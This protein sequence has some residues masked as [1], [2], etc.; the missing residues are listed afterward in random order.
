MKKTIFLASLAVS[1]L[2]ANGNF[3]HTSHWGYT[4]HNSPEH[5]AEIDDRFKMCSLG[6]SQSPINISKNVLVETDDLNPIEFNYHAHS[7]D[8]VNNGHA[9]QVD[10]D[11]H[12][13]INIDGL[14]FVL[15]QFHFHSPSENEI[16]GRSF[17]LE[18]HFVHATK[19]GRL[20]VVA[21]LYELGEKN[22]VLDKIFAAMPKEA[23]HKA[24]LDISSKM[25]DELLPKDKDYY[26][27]SGS[28]TTPPC[29]ENV[30][31][32][33]LKSYQTLSKDQL[34]QFTDV[35]EGNNRPVQPINA[36]KVLK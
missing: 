29:S 35:I 36:R 14:H 7:T 3:G 27:F 31:W 25:I 18:A 34:K 21:V 16:N 9:I 11:S 5:W 26:Y 12:S 13:S 28:L 1:L 4:G 8:V 22:D 15:K 33:V 10:V 20:A 19:D 32:M 23:N 6:K 17:P 2:S 24:P 30:K